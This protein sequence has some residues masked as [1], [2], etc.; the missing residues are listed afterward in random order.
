MLFQSNGFLG[1]LSLDLLLVVD[2]VLMIPIFLALYLSLRGASEPFI[3]IGTLIGFIGIVAYFASNTSFDMLNLSQQYESATTELQKSSLLAAGDAML[4]IFQGTSFHVSYVLTS[5]ATLI[6]S[7]VI[8]K[9]K[10]FGK[11]AGYAGILVAIIG[12]GIYI[13]IIGILLSIIS[14]IPGT[15]WYIFVA[16]QL[17][18]LCRLTPG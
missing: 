14:L 10:L 17:F 12:L 13:P 5:I 8:L 16:R 4:A 7:I 3:T 15:I 11:I 1:L 2:Y 18:Q 6:V 9:S